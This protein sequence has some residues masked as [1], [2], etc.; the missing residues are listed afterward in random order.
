LDLAGSGIR[1][2]AWSATENVM[3]IVAGHISSD[4]AANFFMYRWNGLPDSA[5]E[6]LGAIQHSSG[7]SIEAIL[8]HEGTNSLRLLVDEGA[9]LINGT[10]NKSLPTAQQRFDD[11][12]FTLP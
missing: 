7:G 6:Y 10:E 8:P 12:L 4:P 1:G 3:Y 9:V 11:M 5:P 2:M